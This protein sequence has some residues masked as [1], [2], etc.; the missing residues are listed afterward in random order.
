MS[1]AFKYQGV[2]MSQES[3]QIHYPGVRVKGSSTKVVRKVSNQ[4]QVYTVF[5]WKA[6]I[7]KEQLTRE[8]LTREQRRTLDFNNKNI[9]YD[10]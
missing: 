7:S 4:G 8:Q 6:D 3:N 5:S 10:F 1:N 9:L 2:R